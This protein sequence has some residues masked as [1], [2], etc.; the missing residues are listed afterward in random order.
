LRKFVFGAEPDQLHF[1]RID[2]VHHTIRQTPRPRR[3]VSVAK[4]AKPAA[5]AATLLIFS[6]AVGAS[7]VLLMENDRPFAAGGIT[8]TPTAF[9]EIVLN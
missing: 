4:H 5:M 3:T 2:L 1:R 9:R 6:T 8:L 7:L